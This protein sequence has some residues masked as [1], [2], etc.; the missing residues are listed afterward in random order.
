MLLVVF[1]FLAVFAKMIAV[2]IFDGAALQSRALDQWLRDVPTDAPRG[3]IVDANGAVLAATATRYNLYVRPNDAPDK[4]AV[5]A[6]LSEVFGYDYDDVLAKISKR[7][8]EVTVA[9]RV[10]KEQLN[11]IYASG[12]K[13]IYYSEDNFRYYPYGDFMTQVLGFCSSDGYGQ[14]GLEAYY[15][16]YLTGVNGRLLTPSDLVGRQLDGNSY[17]QPSVAGLTLVTTLDSGVQRIVDG[18]IAAAVA[19]FSPKAVQCIVMNYNTGGIVALSEYP[20]FDLNAVPRDDLEALFSRSKSNCVASVYEPGSTFKILTAAAA[21]DSGAISPTDRFYCNGAKIVD[22]K[23]IRCWKAKGHGSIDFG[24]GVEGSCNVVFMESAL[25]MGTATFYDYLRRFGLTSKTGVDMTGETSGIFIAEKDVKTVDL[26]RVGFGQ[27]VAVTPIGLVAATSAVINGG[28]TVT[29]HLYSSLKD[30]DGRVVAGA[31]QTEGE[32]VISSSTSDEMRSLLMR[33]VTAGSG[34]SAY[35][36]GYEIAGKTG[37]AQKY[38]DGAIASGKYISSFLG[39]LLNDET[40][41]AVLFIVDEP[42]GYM[43]YGS[44]VAAPLVGDIF[45][46]VLAY[47]SVTPHFTGEESEVIGDPFSLPDFTGMTLTQAKSLLSKLGLYFEVDGEGGEVL[48]QYPDAGVTVD[49]RNAVLLL[50]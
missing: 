31:T 20:S 10:D 41:Y 44:L 37:T 39:F 38:K 1:L 25:R 34:K 32:R 18:A 4:P 7:A 19:K 40:P 21:L 15:D 11:R 33:V 6:L 8:S 35:V 5:A 12:L 30:A 23:R 49:K 13:G 24:G 45:R 36:P 2:M 17:Y 50:T 43:Y 42:Q 47:R 26:A 16:K 27:A 14:T 46:S 3:S 48:G 29:P 28:T 9:T 22:G